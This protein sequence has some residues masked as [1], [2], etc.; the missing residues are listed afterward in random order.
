MCTVA[1]FLPLV[2]LVAPETQKRPRHG[3]STLFLPLVF[4]VALG[5]PETPTP[6]VQLPCSLL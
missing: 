6:C 4:L 3:T 1:L 2:F 5:D